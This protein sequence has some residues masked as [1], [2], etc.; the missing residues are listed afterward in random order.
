MKGDVTI[1]TIG[2]IVVAAVTLVLFFIFLPEII[3]LLWKEVALDSPAVV[4]KELAGYIAISG[5]APGS[6]KISYYPS[7][8]PYDAEID[9]RI[10]SVMM[11]EEAEGILER[12]PATATFPIDPIASFAEVNSF[13]ISKSHG[14]YEVDASWIERG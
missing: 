2:L 10:V 7:E 8:Y 14:Q 3:N 11:S 4:S 6:I 12:T 9:N 5:A 13:F 1:N